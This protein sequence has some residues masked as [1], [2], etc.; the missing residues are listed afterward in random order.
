[1]EI[2]GSKHVSIFGLKGESRDSPILLVKNS[3]YINV[4]GYGGNAHPKEGK[5]LFLVED[6]NNFL[7]VNAVD[8]PA[9]FKTK[10]DGGPWHMIIEKR[11]DKL[12]R[13]MPF[14]RP[15]MY[16]A[17]HLGPVKHFQIR[18]HH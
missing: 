3:D 12:I 6:T 10:E 2:R 9:S 4:Y 16:K 8:T 11:G 17:V 13:T 1:M 18:S 7:I 14:D 15:V 5:S